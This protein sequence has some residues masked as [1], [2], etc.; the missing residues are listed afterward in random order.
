VKDTGVVADQVLDEGCFFTSGARFG[1][2]FRW[3]KAVPPAVLFK[4][5][6]EDE[7]VEPVEV[8]FQEA[9]RPKFVNETH[10]KDFFKQYCN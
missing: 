6:C 8:C 3:H 7:F 5:V 9:D 2:L 4:T 10:S 1:K